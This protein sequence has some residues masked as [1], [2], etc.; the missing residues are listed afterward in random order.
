[1]IIKGH[2]NAMV[3]VSLRQQRTKIGSGWEVGFKVG[4]ELVKQTGT[5]TLN[6]IVRNL[7][8][9]QN[10]MWFHVAPLQN[11]NQERACFDFLLE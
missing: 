3:K 8:F 11:S 9:S 1:M 7:D 4:V 6:A 2:E 5:K 10:Q